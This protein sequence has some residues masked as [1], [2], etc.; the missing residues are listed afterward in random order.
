MRYH[1]M[2]IRSIC[3]SSLSLF[4]LSF[5]ISVL[6]VNAQQI[7]PNGYTDTNLHSYGNVTDVTTA[8]VK[9]N[10][11]FNSFSKFNVDKGNVV[12]LII[13]DQANNLI[14]VIKD[15]ATHIN[16]TLNS[17]KG[18]NIGGNVFLVNPNG[19]FVGT[20][21]EVNVGS[22]T[23]V[24]PTKDFIDKFF[25]SPGNPNPDAVSAVL[26]G[27]APNNPDVKIEINGI[28]NFVDDST[29]DEKQNIKN[30]FND[31]NK[32]QL[33]KGVNTDNIEI[34]NDIITEK[35]GE[36]I[37]GSV[38]NI[39]DPY[40]G[41]V[42]LK[43]KNEL[44]GNDKVAGGSPIPPLPTKEN[45]Q[46]NFQGIV[47][48]NPVKPAEQNQT[49]ERGIITTGPLN[50]VGYIDPDVGPLPH[51]NSDNNP[52]GIVTTG[53]VKPVGDSNPLG[54]VTTGPIKPVGDSNPLGIVTTG[55]IK[56]VGDSNPLG[57]VTTGPVK[58]VGDSNPLGIVTTGPIKPVGDSNPLGIVTT[59]PVKPVGDS[60]PLGIVTTG[61]VKP[62]IKEM[63]DNK[64]NVSVSPFV[65]LKGFNNKMQLKSPEV[66]ADNALLQ[67]G[68]RHFVYYPYKLGSGN[69]KA[70]ADFKAH[71]LG[72]V[73]QKANIVPPQRGVKTGSVLMKASFITNSPGNQIKKAKMIIDYK[74]DIPAN[75]EIKQKAVNVIY[76][77]QLSPGY[78][79]IIAPKRHMISI[80]HNII[81]MA[82][83]IGN[84]LIRDNSETTMSAEPVGPSIGS[85][86]NTPQSSID[87]RGIIPT[88]PF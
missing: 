72:D 14:N 8:T 57:I 41:P 34:A 46:E 7:T 16:G 35:D 38:L 10:N 33:I 59:G 64:G 13:P 84:E 81:N 15:E 58:P 25:D 48:V 27:T 51:V 82:A 44:I 73:A 18:G 20:T 54:I 31:N 47:P 21:G 67:V 62:I 87:H 42:I 88:T 2:D 45:I 19:I 11:A 85:I 65:P 23:N 63:I 74:T 78:R 4:A 50:P 37:I 39:D 6:P 5:T 22:L 71:H 79:H 75:A 69:L 76:G 83:N 30:D 77:A 60:N 26:N 32:K 3:L 66:Q 9:G 55:P 80:K 36:I 24:T 17:I 40:V 43:D 52:L 1:V 29:L 61:P 56:P 68:Y 49:S 53:P 28:I 86:R 12:N 70:K